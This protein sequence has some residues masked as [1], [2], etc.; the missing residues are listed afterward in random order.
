VGSG[1][2][3]VVDIIIWMPDVGV[4]E[5]CRPEISGSVDD[6]VVALLHAL[7]ISVSANTVNWHLFTGTPSSLGYPS[8]YYYVLSWRFLVGDFCSSLCYFLFQKFDNC[9]E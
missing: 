2:D 3:V 4:S 7:K 1:E 6:L 9:I 8:G 5:S